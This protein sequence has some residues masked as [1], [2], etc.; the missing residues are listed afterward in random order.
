MVK[1]NL[2]KLEIFT[3][4]AHT[5]CV[6]RDLKKKIA[7]DMYS[8]GTGIV[9]HALALKIYNSQGETEF[10]NEEYN[11]LMDYARQALTPATID[12]LDAFK[13]KEQENNNN[14]K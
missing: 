5:T 11:V 14:N 6:V 10:S 9:F 7:E 12:A 4:I 8:H 3:D 2:E 13:P 1:I